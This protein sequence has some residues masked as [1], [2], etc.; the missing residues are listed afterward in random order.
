MIF[1][2]VTVDNEGRGKRPAAK[3]SISREFLS[4][5]PKLWLD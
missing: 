4:V 2:Q 5:V 1:F 3:G